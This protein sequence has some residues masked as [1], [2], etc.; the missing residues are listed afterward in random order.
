VPDGERWQVCTEP[1]FK[2]DCRIVE[3]SVANL[4]L[5]GLNNRITSMRKAPEELTTPEPPPPAPTAKT[6][7]KPSAEPPAKPSKKPKAEAE[8]PTKS[9]KPKAEAEAEAEV[10][11]KP[12]KP[13]AATQVPAPTAALPEALPREWWEGGDDTPSVEVFERPNY[14]GRRVRLEEAVADLTKLEQPVGSLLV[15]AGSW[16]VC[17]RPR[18]RGHCQTL[19]PAVRAGGHRR[20][21]S[22]RNGVSC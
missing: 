13:P 21:A 12:S 6:P 20:F 2:G 10:P 17:S 14:Q 8:L 9:P 18:F 4:R 5:L 7:A 16:R 22:A 15:R 11:A 1:L 3:G 19:T